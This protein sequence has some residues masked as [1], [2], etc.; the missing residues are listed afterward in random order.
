[1]FDR[2]APAYD[3]QGV[4]FF[5]PLGAA[6]VAATVVRPGDTVVDLACG[7]GAV[8]FPAAAATGPTGTITAVDLAPTMVELTRTDV[9]GRGLTQ[10][11]VTLG[12]AEHPPV[13]PGTVDVV[14]CGMGLFLLPDP[15]A[16][17]RRWAGLLRASGGRLGVSVF[18]TPD[19]RWDGPDN[20]VRRAVPQPRSTRRPG[21]S[22]LSAGV[23]EQ[24]LTDAGLRDATDRTVTPDVVFRDVEH[25][26]AWAMGTG[27]RSQLER[28][29][30][31]DRPALVT[32]LTAWHAGATDAAGLHWRPAIRIVTATRPRPA[33]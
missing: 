2:A 17:V 10:V 6:L 11:D 5:G 30:D 25:W 4:S 20:P 14:L 3:T 31:A 32:E 1:M 19:P 29:A 28:V 12:D 13:A 27:I 16:A 26:W 18:G 7:R 22:I 9:R 8:L 15:V 33:D 23:L 24:A 21:L